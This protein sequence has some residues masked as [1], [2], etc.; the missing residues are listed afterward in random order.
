M[1]RSWR[2]RGSLGSAVEGDFL[3]E[4]G[5]TEEIQP[6]SLDVGF[7]CMRLPTAPPACD[8]GKT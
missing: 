1:L 2:A 4:R 7:P 6:Q 5:E 8:S 3:Q